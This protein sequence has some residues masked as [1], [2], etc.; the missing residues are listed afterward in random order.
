[1]NVVLNPELEAAIL[2]HISGG[3]YS[4][5]EA[6]LEDALKALNEKERAR[7]F[8]NQKIDRGISQLDCGQ[9]V[10]GDQFFERLLNREPG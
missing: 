4:T 8:I 6:V 5:A 10:D 7:Q 2:T 9:S 3:R 1:M